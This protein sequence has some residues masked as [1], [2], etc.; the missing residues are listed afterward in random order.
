[1]AIYT[2][3]FLCE[4]V[5]A[6]HTAYG[7]VFTAIRII[8]RFVLK[9]PAPQPGMVVTLPPILF[10]AVLIF[11]SD[12]PETFTVAME[13][14]HANG[15][16]GQKDVY[17]VSTEGGV[18]G[19]KF[20][21]NMVGNPVDPGLAWFDIFVNDS[22]ALRLPFIIEHEISSEFRNYSPPPPQ[23]TPSA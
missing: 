9:I 10:S 21:V 20:H 15:A 19:H 17:Q 8:D 3:G 23:E 14:V 13:A 4:K 6:E 5:I 1:M 22:L 12:G 18:K 2:T 7:D 11:K 16:R